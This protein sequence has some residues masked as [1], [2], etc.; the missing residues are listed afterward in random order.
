MVIGL[1]TPFFTLIHSPSS[2][3][4]GQFVMGQMSYLW[5]SLLSDSLIR[6]PH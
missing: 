3:F 6:Q 5:D 1:K 2:V 4:I